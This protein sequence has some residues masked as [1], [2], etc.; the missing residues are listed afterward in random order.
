MDPATRRAFYLGLVGLIL[1]GSLIA[2]FQIKP[3]PLS[4]LAKDG[5]VSIYFASMSSGSQGNQNLQVSGLSFV[6]S[7]EAANGHGKPNATITSLN[8]TIDSVTVHVAGQGNESGWSSNLLPRTFTIDILKATNLATLIASSKLPAGN[9]T[10]VR[11]GVSSAT[12]A[13]KDSQTEK[14]T[15]VQV[16]VS[17]GK[18][19]VPLDS[20]ARVS[21]QLTTSITLG[22]PHIVQEGNGQIRLTPV[23][24]PLVS[25][26]N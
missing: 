14:V 9:I 21:P 19:E 26:P 1:A 4:I 5:T 25:G 23:L 10:T 6:S 8:V 2:V 15:L 11:L 3:I 7:P 17:S 12:A 18:L 20:D 16:D 22:R 24:H 13:V